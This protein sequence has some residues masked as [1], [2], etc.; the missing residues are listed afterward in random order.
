MTGSEMK[1]ITLAKNGLM[2]FILLENW[3]FSNIERREKFNIENKMFL[4]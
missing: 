3:I 4:L 2:S 1:K